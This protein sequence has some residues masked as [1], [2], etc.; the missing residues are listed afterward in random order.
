[1]VLSSTNRVE[2][3][4]LD[5]LTFFFLQFKL[6]LFFNYSMRVD[7]KKGIFYTKDQLVRINFL[8]KWINSII[9]DLT[10]VIVVL[11]VLSQS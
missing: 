1:M 11:T 3:S 5:L 7:R 9:E 6:Q 10:T 8:D 4:D 2:D